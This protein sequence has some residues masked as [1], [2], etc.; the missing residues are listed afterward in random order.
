ML[1]L[2]IAITL[3]YF[4]P[5][6]I[7]PFL[8]EGPYL[9]LFLST[10]SLIFIAWLGTQK[11]FVA[12]S[13]IAIESLSIAINLSG[14]LCYMA[15]LKSA[16][17]YE[18]RPAIISACFIAELLIIGA[19]IL[20]V[21]GVDAHIFNLRHSGSNAFAVNRIGF[22]ASSEGKRCTTQQTTY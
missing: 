21:V 22:Y 15:S 13:F 5:D 9:F 19:R 11:G 6:L 20:Y 17:I 16:Y 14:A 2:L 4:M 3:V 7:I 18:H 10:W 8:P 12:T 1:K